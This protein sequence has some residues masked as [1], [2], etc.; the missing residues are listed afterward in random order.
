MEREWE[1]EEETRRDRGVVEE[2]SGCEGRAED[3]VRLL[4]PSEK[5]RMRD[6]IDASLLGSRSVCISGAE[7]ACPWDEDVGDEKS[8]TGDSTIT[9]APYSS[10]YVSEAEVV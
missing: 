1:D 9:S 4:N 10:V 5:R 6:D 7:R 8:L 2:L 3:D